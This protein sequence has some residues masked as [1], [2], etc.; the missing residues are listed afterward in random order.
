MESKNNIEI[1]KRI[2]NSRKALKMSMKALGEKVNLHESTISRYE[3]GEIQSLDIEKLKEFANAL[4]VP[5]SFLIGWEDN[6]QS[7]PNTYTVG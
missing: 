5:P 2:Y 3:K 4:E 6:E 1:G 7:P